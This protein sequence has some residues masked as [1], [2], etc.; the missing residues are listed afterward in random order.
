[1][2]NC[3]DLSGI[4]KNGRKEVSTLTY[5]HFSALLSTCVFQFNP[6]SSV[7]FFQLIFLSTQTFSLS[8]DLSICSV[9]HFLRQASQPSCIPLNITH[10]SPFFRSCYRT[11]P[12]SLIRHRFSFHYANSQFFSF[13]FSSGVRAFLNP[14]SGSI[15]LIR[16][17]TR[18]APLRVRQRSRFNETP[19]KSHKNETSSFFE[20][21]VF[22]F[23]DESRGGDTNGPSLLTFSF[24]ER[25]SSLSVPFLSLNF[26]FINFRS[27]T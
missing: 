10:S 3:E 22:F 17:Y 7:S 20:S 8:S 5:A 2:T 11:T 21:N 24:Q 9:V 18:R 26:L 12:I 25:P 4:Q 14:A 23:N 1:M 19:L 27:K 13:S 6:N 15:P 16:H